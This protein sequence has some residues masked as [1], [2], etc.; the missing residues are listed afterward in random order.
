MNDNTLISITLKS[1][2]PTVNHMYMN[3]HGR[4]FRTAECR[5][6]QEQV[7][8]QLKALWNNKPPFTGR[9]AIHIIFT[10]KDKRRWDIDNRMKAIQDCLTMAG[11]IK[12]DSQIDFLQIERL[13]KEDISTVLILKEI[14]D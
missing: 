8:E 7:V 14:K 10:A 4:R 2:P 9:A 13:Y 11:I 3:A 1:L 5:E 6:Y 12:D